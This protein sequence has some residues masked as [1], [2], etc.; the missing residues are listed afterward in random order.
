MQAT[1]RGNGG[2]R[3]YFTG[4]SYQEYGRSFFCD[5]ICSTENIDDHSLL[6]KK[7]A[8]VSYGVMK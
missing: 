8:K 1:A 4:K 2:N 6:R 5:I 7:N 3:K